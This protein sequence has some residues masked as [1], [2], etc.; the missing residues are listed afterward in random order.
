VV[1]RTDEIRAAIRL[2]DRP[3]RNCADF[4]A[5]T[6]GMRRALATRRSS[7]SPEGAMNE[8]SNGTRG[9]KAVYTIIERKGLEKSLW[10]RIGTAFTNDDQSINVRLDALPINGQIQIREV[11]DAELERA[12]QRR[13]EREGTTRFAAAGAM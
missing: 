7:H 3:T 10:L 2:A 1:R 8:N 12:R 9:W 4:F 6:C 5:A 11:S 13:I